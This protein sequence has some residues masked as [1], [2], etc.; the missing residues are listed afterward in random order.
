VV[1]AALI[2]VLA[3]YS[4]YLRIQ[5]GGLTEARNSLTEEVLKES[6]PTDEQIRLAEAA[7]AEFGR[8]HGYS[9]LCNLVVLVLVT[10]ATGMAAALPS[11]SAALTRRE[12]DETSSPKKE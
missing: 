8:V 1:V 4:C 9:L 11:A 2:G 10:A 6:A 12:P 5:T 3:G 7:R